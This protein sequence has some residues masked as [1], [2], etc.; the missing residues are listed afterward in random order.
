MSLGAHSAPPL[1]LTDM[2]GLTRNIKQKRTTIKD[3]DIIFT[4]NL[5]QPETQLKGLV[6]FKEETLGYT[7]P[8]TDEKAVLRFRKSYR[9]KYLTLSRDFKWIAVELLNGRRKAWVPRQTVEVLDRDIRQKLED[10]PMP[11]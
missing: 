7:H 11:R 9:A 1:D 10:F 8:N 5:A 6:E 3:N 2:S 4:D